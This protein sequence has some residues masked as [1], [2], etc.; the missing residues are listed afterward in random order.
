VDK[1][2]RADASE[3]GGVKDVVG[4]ASDASLGVGVEE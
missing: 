1:G 4:G 2:S 3:V